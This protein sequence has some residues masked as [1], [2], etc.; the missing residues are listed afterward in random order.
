MKS[1]WL[2]AT[3][4]IALLAASEA[5]ADIV[6]VT[7]DGTVYS[8]CDPMGTFGQRGCNPNTDPTVVEPYVGL[9][10]EATFLFDTSK[11]QTFTSPTENYAQG[12]NKPWLPNACHQRDG[13]CQRAR[14]QHRRDNPGRD[15]GLQWHISR[16]D[17]QPDV[18]SAKP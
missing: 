7:Y 12:G 6:Q 10:Y 5:R 3:A 16:P 14:P 9:P 15:H 13:H 11:G 17:C 2:A 8:A 1:Y 18:Q 4:A